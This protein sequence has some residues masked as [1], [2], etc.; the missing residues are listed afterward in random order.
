MWADLQQGILEDFSAFT[1]KFDS[2][3]GFR[4]WN[5]HARQALELARR[6]YKTAKQ[7]EYD[8]AKKSTRVCSACGGGLGRP[9]R[10]LA[11]CL[12]CG[13]KNYVEAA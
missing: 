12:S 10:Q 7:R 9:Y 4:V 6:A 2:R 5:V 8:L 11:A 3:D 1:P 13:A